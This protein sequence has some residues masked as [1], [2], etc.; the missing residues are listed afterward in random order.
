[1]IDS[2][3]KLL[4]NKCNLTTMAFSSLKKMSE[5]QERKEGNYASS[6]KIS[7]AR[8]TIFDLGLTLLSGSQIQR[9]DEKRLEDAA[10]S[11]PKNL[12]GKDNGRSGNW[13]SLKTVRQQKHAA[14][15]TVFPN[16]ARSRSRSSD[17]DPGSAKPSYATAPIGRE[18]PSSINSIIKDASGTSPLKA[19]SSAA[20]PYAE[21]RR[22]TGEIGNT[23]SR[24]HD[25]SSP[26]AMKRRELGG[27]A[28]YE[29]ADSRVG[30][31]KEVAFETHCNRFH[32]HNDQGLPG[33]NA[34]H[35]R[36]G[37]PSAAKTGTPFSAT[38][39]GLAS[40]RSAS[41]RQ[42]THSPDTALAC[43]C[44]STTIEPEDTSL[45]GNPSALTALASK[46]PARR[47]QSKSEKLT[48]HY[49]PPNSSKAV[50][51]QHLRHSRL[52]P[53]TPAKIGTQ[54]LKP[55]KE[56]NRSSWTS[57][58]PAKAK[59]LHR[60]NLA[61]PSSPAAPFT[62]SEDHEHP[63]LINPLS[64]STNLPASTQPSSTYPLPL[65]PNFLGLSRS[66]DNLSDVHALEE[67]FDAAHAGNQ[68][69]LAR[70]RSASMPNLSSPFPPTN[71]NRYNNF[72]P[73]SMLTPP[74]EQPSSPHLPYSSSS[75]QYDLTS[76][77][78]NILSP[79]VSNDGA[80]AASGPQYVRRPL[81]IKPHYSHEEVKSLMYTL[82]RQSQTIKSE[83]TNL[84][85][86]NAA[87]KIMVE[88]LQYKNT[89]LTQQIQRYERTV[90][91]NNQQIETMQKKGSSLQHQF[92][93]LWD[94]HNRLLAA[95]RKENGTENPSAIAKR[96]RESHLP[97]AVGAASQGRQPGANA[98]TV[99]CGNGAQLPA[100]RDGLE[101]TPTASQG[102]IRP[103][104]L[105]GPSDANE[106]NTSSQALPQQGYSAANYNKGN[107]SQKVSISAYPSTAV[108]QT[109][110]RALSQPGFAPANHD[111]ANSPRDGYS[112][113]VPSNPS[114][115]AT[116]RAMI[117]NDQNKDRPI[118][119]VSTERVTIDLTGDSQ[120][121]SSSASLTTPVEQMRHSSA[122]GG[123]LPTSPPTD[124][125]PPAHHSS[126]H[127]V[128]SQYP[129]GLSAQ[130]PMPN[131]Q[132]TPDQGSQ[133]NNLEAMQIQ[134]ETYARMAKKPLSWLQGENPFRRGT[135]NEQ[136]TGLPDSRR[137]SSSN[138]EEHF[139]LAQSSEA[140][141]VA[142]L[143][144]TASG[145][146]TKNTAPKKPRILLDAAA[147]KEKAKIYRKTAAEKKKREKAIAEQLLQDA[148][149]SNNTMRAQKQ[150]RR[151]AKEV[152][153]QEQARKPSE[154][155]GPR[156]PQRTLDG[157]LHQEGTGVQQAMHGGSVEKVAL[158]GRDSL[159]EDDEDGGVEMEDIQS[160]PDADSIMED[161]AASTEEFVDSVY[162]A[163]LEAILEAD[164]DA[165][166]GVEQ[167][168]GLHDFS[169]ESEESEEE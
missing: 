21:Q 68:C 169:S 29:M 95:I 73:A 15:E 72:Q 62:P 137:S 6:E 56:V 163:E 150:D 125:Y 70:R 53:N 16:K 37:E 107:P 60:A 109:L 83:N 47:Q 80:M 87:M 51:T 52:V 130:N 156:E 77:R 111:N 127:N 141:N 115:G 98:S 91:H 22:G 104:V 157:R 44:Q 9:K 112:R 3:T 134:K 36:K 110:S 20:A 46:I 41:H 164:V 49:Q 120:P 2:S 19:K 8:F 54:V 27:H 79:S 75:L 84:Q 33:V 159:F 123:Y 26:R 146:K 67:I 85:A 93:R 100:S 142:P 38:V 165:G 147:K 55:R 24:Q 86:Q 116:A 94:D 78:Q 149:T 160:S 30:K 132:L 59:I 136:G 106:A 108:A 153:R 128:L 131:S 103:V 161:N 88:S 10:E 31:G 168:D 25:D 18:R 166:I 96:I 14:Q 126:G 119:Q 133:D 92:K 42:T 99:C 97:N 158:D 135:K 35:L 145:R 61:A 4:P 64:L 48:V 82:V 124:Q 101:Q 65:S 13:K 71:M 58:F 154:E 152:F 151:V 89:N 32:M 74:R 113:W 121:P 140:G 66:F 118:E 43:S 28:S 57:H 34:I 90:V 114:L 105:V 63:Q 81:E 143:P 117:T 5:V 1:M 144:E 167:D 12:G 102:H 17:P 155:V 69:Q 139:L 162:E 23:D 45:H 50:S 7:L 76:F 138:A 148:N 129:S 40:S 11:S 122:Q 39:G